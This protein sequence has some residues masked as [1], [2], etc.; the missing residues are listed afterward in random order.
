VRS[1]NEDEARRLEEEI[2]GKVF[3]GE[4]ELALAMTRHVLERCAA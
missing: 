4:T 1:H 3:V 2:A